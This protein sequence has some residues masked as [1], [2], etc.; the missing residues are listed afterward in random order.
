MSVVADYFCIKSQQSRQQIGGRCSERDIAANRRC[1]S[2]LWITDGRGCFSQCL[3]V[4]ANGGIDCNPC[5]GHGIGMTAAA[6]IADSGD[7]ID[8]DAETE[9]RG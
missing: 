5:R 2:D 1:S 4:L 8:V 9:L 6:R 3:K 7:M